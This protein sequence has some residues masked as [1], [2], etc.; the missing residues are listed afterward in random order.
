[1]RDLLIS[2]NR[3]LSKEEFTKL[4]LEEHQNE[5]DL[6]Q[7]VYNF[8][9]LEIH[10]KPEYFAYYSYF[11]DCLLPYTEEDSFNSLFS[12]TRQ[13]VKGDKLGAQNYLK[14]STEKKEKLYSV[15]RSL[16]TS[17]LQENY[18][19][20]L[21]DYLSPT[22]KNTVA[23]FEIIKE[24]YKQEGFSLRDTLLNSKLD[25]PKKVDSQ[26]I[27]G[28]FYSELWRNEKENAP[29]VIENFMS[30][31]NFSKVEL[32]QALFTGPYAAHAEFLH[33]YKEKA[34]QVIGTPFESEFFSAYKFNI[35]D[36]EKIELRKS[37]D[38]QEF[39]EAYLKSSVKKASIA[40]QER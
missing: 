11:M 28:D 37:K 14:T 19:P 34:P 17:D 12:L 33:W 25:D 27:I 15:E 21:E 22:P 23:S 32:Q 10:K 30:K 26:M 3:V 1:M 35:S 5:K 39:E 29:K 24:A 18:K 31:D 38:F 36:E 13:W 6:N 16:A 2:E 20:F 4:F 8:L 40:T 7:I 9:S